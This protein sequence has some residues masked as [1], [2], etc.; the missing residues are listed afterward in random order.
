MP[1]HIARRRAVEAR[2]VLHLDL[3]PERAK[4]RA[5]VERERGR[6][7]KG[8]GMHPDPRDRPRPRQL[9]RAAHQKSPGAAADQF[10]GDAEE[11]EFALAGLAE[12]E[13]K[14]T[15]VASVL[16]QRIDFDQRR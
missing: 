8:A 13:F 6:M 5:L 16:H 12:I 15:L 14:Q 2:I 4:A 1:C 10:C 3:P 9:Q 7:I 11:G